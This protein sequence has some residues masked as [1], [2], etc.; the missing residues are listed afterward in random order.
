VPRTGTALAINAHPGMLDR[1]VALVRDARDAG[2][3][4]A[5]DSLRRS[6]ARRLAALG[7]G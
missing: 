7:H 1:S 5:S 6:C 2:V 4:F 3:K